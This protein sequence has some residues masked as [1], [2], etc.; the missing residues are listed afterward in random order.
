MQGLGLISTASR[1]EPLALKPGGGKGAKVVILVHLGG[2]GDSC[3]TKGLAV[4]NEE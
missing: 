1:A 3:L 4:W 2:S